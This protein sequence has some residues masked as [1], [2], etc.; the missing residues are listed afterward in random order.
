M[1]KNSIWIF[2]IILFFGFAFLAVWYLPVLPKTFTSTSGVKIYS[3]RYPL[4]YSNELGNSNDSIKFKNIPHLS[5]LD[6]STI[7]GVTEPLDCQGLLPILG[8]SKIS[9]TETLA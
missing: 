2:S 5:Y 8:Q 9:S 4:R 3:I 7:K 1:L 6:E